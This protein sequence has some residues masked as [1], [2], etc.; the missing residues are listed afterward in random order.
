MQSTKRLASVDGLRGIAILLIVLFHFRLMAEGCAPQSRLRALLEPAQRGG[1]AIYFFLILS[2]F[3]LTHSLIRKTRSGRAPA[4]LDYLF[5]RWRRIAPPYYVA[6]FL[7]LAT[8]FIQQA[9]NQRALVIGEGTYRQI[10]VHLLFVHGFWADT[11]YA[12]STPLWFLSMLFQL[13]LV[14]PLLFALAE[15]FGYLLVI[16]A[17][18]AVS[19]AWRLFLVYGVR[20]HFYL[21]DGVF[22]GHLAEFAIGMWIAAWC[23]RPDRPPVSHVLCP[24][25]FV[26]ALV[27]LT[28]GVTLESLYRF[29]FFDVVL[30]AAFGAILMAALASDEY[31]GLFGRTC[32]AAPLVWTGEISYSLYLTHGLALGW[33]SPIYRRI[34]PHSANTDDIF[35]VA[36][37]GSILGVGWAFYRMVESPFWLKSARK[38]LKDAESSRSE[39]RAFVQPTD[40]SRS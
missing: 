13:Y 6:T 9:I 10:I 15:K 26:S 28:G 7:Y 32:A 16:P 34:L 3:S 12:I 35:L 8:A 14:L 24:L 40:A 17:M 36:A 38:R 30:G 37:F 29:L 22:L 18:V 31:R 5:E 20:G 11:I 21:A 4:V 33:V 19:L 1:A 39:G 25:C 23:N 2:G 27:L